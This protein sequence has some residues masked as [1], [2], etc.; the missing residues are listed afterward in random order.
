MENNSSRT[1]A[2]PINSTNGDKKSSK[3]QQGKEMM[4]N[5]GIICYRVFS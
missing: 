4:K 1:D 5:N 2:K 3:P